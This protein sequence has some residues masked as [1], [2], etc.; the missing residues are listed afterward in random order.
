[1][2]SLAGTINSSAVSRKA[3]AAGWNTK[4]E[5]ETEGG[6]K[7][8]GGREAVFSAAR[9]ELVVERGSVRHVDRPASIVVAVLAQVRVGA[10]LD[11][12]RR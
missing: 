7:G 6:G 5:R 3:G 2:S 8:E 10:R 12:E 11:F 9:A 1:M 4:Q